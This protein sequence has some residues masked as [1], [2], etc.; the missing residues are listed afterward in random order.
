MSGPAGESLPLEEWS[1]EATA[2]LALIFNFGRSTWQMLRRRKPE[3][4]PLYW[5]RVNPWAGR[6]ADDELEEAVGALL[7]NGRP[8]AA[9]DLISMAMLRR[10]RCAGRTSLAL[11]RI[12]DHYETDAKWHDEHAEARN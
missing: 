3:A 10:V 11:R 8:M 6:L 12:A 7:Q 2:K 1:A 9:V 4:E 5:R